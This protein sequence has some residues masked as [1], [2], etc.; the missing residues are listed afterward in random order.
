MRVLALISA[1]ATLVLPGAIAHA[2]QEVR[3]I[4]FGGDDQRTRIVIEVAEPSYLQ[5]FTLNEINNRL[6]LD[7]PSSAWQVSGLDTGEGM[8]RW[9]VDTFRFFDRSNNSSRLVFELEH[10]AII[11][12]QFT[13]D[14]AEGSSNHRIV[15]DLERSTQQTARDHVGIQPTASGIDGLIAERVEAVYMPPAR[16]RR[17][18]VIDA[19]HGG[20]D[21]GAIGRGGTHESTVT[22][23]AARELRRQL[24][25]TGRYEVR[26]TRDRD[27]YPSWEDRIGLMADA[28]ADLFLSLHAD[29]SSNPNVRGAAV[30]TLNDRAEDRARNRAR[31]GAEHSDQPDVNNILVELELREKR[32]QSSVFAGVLLD[33]LDDASPLLTNP[34]RQANFFV[35]L[36]P[37][38]PAVL[39]E[40]GFLSN[41]TDEVN[42]NS[43]RFRRDQMESVVRG[44]D[45]Y[46]ERRGD[47]DDL[48]GSNPAVR[49]R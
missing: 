40:M 38:V 23:A 18:I 29:S 42:L 10:A 48:D 45:I 25:A 4:R 43:D 37:R 44:I 5:A 2:D 39:L 15:I 17:V 20:H 12:N 32:N 41:R 30:Y 47:D 16:E 36:D 11:A 7:L 34:H 24:E 26:M 35:L 49:A 19:G 6:V 46:F 33:H 27:V 9:L 28:R 13:L 8:G 31:Q 22:L 21:P 3:N 14:P 1:I